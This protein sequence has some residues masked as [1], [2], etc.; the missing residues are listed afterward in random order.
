MCKSLSEVAL[1]SKRRIYRGRKTKLHEL[2]GHTVLV[3]GS[4]LSARSWGIL[5]DTQCLSELIVQGTTCSLTWNI[6]SDRLPPM[7]YREA[8]ST[9]IFP[10]ITTR[11]RRYFCH[12][13]T[14]AQRSVL[15]TMVWSTS[16]KALEHFNTCHVISG[17]IIPLRPTTSRS[18]WLILHVLRIS[19]ALW[20]RSGALMRLGSTTAIIRRDYTHILWLNIAGTEAG[21]SRVQI[22][23]ETSV[24]HGLD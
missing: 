14:E 22:V 13:T 19:S 7:T 4:P 8:T 17:Y 15:R 12:F 23:R 2:T 3:R 16:A 18:C 6:V 10:E 11:L 24:H 1:L 20:T 21:E 5:L 9:Y